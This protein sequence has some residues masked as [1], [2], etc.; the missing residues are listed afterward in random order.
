MKKEIVKVFE[1]LEAWRDYCRF[2][3]LKFD[4]ADLYKSRAWREFAG[5]DA[6]KIRSS[7]KSKKPKK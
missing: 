3:G 5:L 2:N 6:K 4:E 7:N 1:D